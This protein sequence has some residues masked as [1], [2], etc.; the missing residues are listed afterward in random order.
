MGS[1]TSKIEASAVVEHINTDM[2]CTAQE[3][4][5]TACEEYR[6]HKKDIE[7]I[8]EKVFDN[9]KGQ[10]RDAFEKDYRTLKSQLKDLEDVILDL[11]TGIIEAEEQYI[12]ADAEI[13]KAIAVADASK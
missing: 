12:N 3:A 4:F 1:S 9:W 8:V 13:S 5:V 6:A 11:R 7:N 10:G 2:M